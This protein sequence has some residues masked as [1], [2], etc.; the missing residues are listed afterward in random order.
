LLAWRAAAGGFVTEAARAAGL[1]QA[2]LVIPVFAA[3][4]AVVLAGGARA[5]GAA[6]R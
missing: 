5:A 3:A 4:L 2:M 1:H 6:R